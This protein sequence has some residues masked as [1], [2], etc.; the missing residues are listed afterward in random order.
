MD[1]SA[2]IRDPADPK[3]SLKKT[4]YKKYLFFSLILPI[5]W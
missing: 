1:V 3:F 5:D 4:C 2:G